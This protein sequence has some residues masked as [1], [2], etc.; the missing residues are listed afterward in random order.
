MGASIPEDGEYKFR[1]INENK[2]KATVFYKNGGKWEKIKSSNRGKYVKFTVDSPE[3]TI[4]VRYESALLSKCITAAVIVL[5]LAA[6]V[7]VTVTVVK[8]HKRKKS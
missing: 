4:A 7:F 2:D 1:I 6:A 5:I 3:V 8:K